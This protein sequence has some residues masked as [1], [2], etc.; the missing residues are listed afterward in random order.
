M[1]SAARKLRDDGMAQAAAH[2]PSYVDALYAAI[3]IVAR[4]QPTVHVNDLS[5]HSLPEP[6][7]R[8][9]AGPAWQRAVHGGVLQ[10]TN[11]FRECT[12]P[13]KRARMAPVYFSLIYDPRSTP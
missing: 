1:T 3:G 8:N 12:D 10:R 5:G 7:H 6:N 4:R 11:Q 9:A 2:S 13:A